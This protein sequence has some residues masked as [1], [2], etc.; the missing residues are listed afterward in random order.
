ME[1]L[2]TGTISRHMNHKKVVYNSQHRFKGKSRLTNLINTYDEMTGLV[3]KGGAVDVVY[4][5]FNKTFDTVS[6]K[7]LTD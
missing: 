5:D 1:Q 2:N 7:I 3:D 6:R 4:L